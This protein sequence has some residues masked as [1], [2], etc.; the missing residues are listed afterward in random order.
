[1]QG[2]WLEVTLERANIPCMNGPDCSFRAWPF[3]HNFGIR[4][5]AQNFLPNIIV[6]GICGLP[7]RIE[8]H[9]RGQKKKALIRTEGMPGRA[10]R[11]IVAA[12]RLVEKL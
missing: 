5:D 4:F 9:A 6:P 10:R 11:N 8:P 12:K 3:A 1:M 2:T 7:I